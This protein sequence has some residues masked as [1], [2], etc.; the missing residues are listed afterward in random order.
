MC[1]IGKVLGGCSSINAMV[2][3]RGHRENYEGWPE[4]WKYDDVVPFYKVSENFQTDI[5]DDG[6]I[7]NFQN[8]W[9]WHNH[10]Y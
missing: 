4:G 3:V 1:V 6:G 8:L 10:E 2:Y 5:A 7:A 9:R